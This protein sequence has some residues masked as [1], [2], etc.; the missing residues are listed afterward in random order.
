[1]KVKK[2]V[3]FIS[4]VIVF[5]AILAVFIKVSGEYSWRTLLAF[6]ALEGWGL[7]SFFFGRRLL[8]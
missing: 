6:V 4:L 2:V 1:M 3:T 5:L 8:R 7:L